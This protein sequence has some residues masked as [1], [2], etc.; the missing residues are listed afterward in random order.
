M[1]HKIAH[2]AGLTLAADLDPGDGRFPPETEMSLYRI[3]QESFNNVLKHADARHVLVRLQA[4]PAAVNLM[5]QD[6]G[7]GFDPATSNQEERRGFGLLGIAERVRLL[8]GTC[9][10]QSKPGAGTTVS[11]HLPLPASTNIAC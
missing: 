10:L 4:T 2:S 6:D 5:V 7:K 8:G 1:L 9:T 11:I 3:V